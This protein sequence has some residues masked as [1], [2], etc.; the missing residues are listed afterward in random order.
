MTGPHET[1]EHETVTGGWRLGISALV[2][3]ATKSGARDRR[4]ADC[5]GAGQCRDDVASIRKPAAPFTADD[6]ARLV[7]IWDEWHLNDMRAAC[8]HMSLPRDTSYDAQRGITC[9]RVSL[10]KDRHAYRYGAAWLYA[11]LPDD[12]VSFV[13]EFI[14]KAHAAS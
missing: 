8:A 11:P 14:R 5:I 9:P 1:I 10:V 6:V 12:V 4:Y 2:Y 7:A 13:R 3:V